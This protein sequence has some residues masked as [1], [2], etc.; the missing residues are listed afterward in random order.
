M[1]K[2]SKNIALGK[3]LYLVLIFLWLI[4][5]T[6]IY[7]TAVAITNAIISWMPKT[8]TVEQDETREMWASIFHWIVVISAVILIPTYLRGKIEKLKEK[9]NIK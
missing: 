8:Y 2:N 5:V 9:F 7:S 6:L 4:L 3:L 1:S